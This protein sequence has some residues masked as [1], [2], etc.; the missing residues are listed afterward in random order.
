L[1]CAALRGIDYRSPVLGGPGVGEADVWFKAVAW[2]ENS[3]ELTDHVQLVALLLA[4]H[5]D[6]NAKDAFDRAPLIFAAIGGRVEIARMLIEAGADPRA[7]FRVVDRDCPGRTSTALHCAA[8]LGFLA[9]VD[10]LLEFG[11]DSLALS[12]GGVGDGLRPIGLAARS[13]WWE[14]VA[15]LRSAE[16]EA[17]RQTNCPTERPTDEERV[18][19]G[20]NGVVDAPVVAIGSRAAQTSPLTRLSQVRSWEVIAALVALLLLFV[21]LTFG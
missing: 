2:H 8:G 3:C 5:A 12:I 7:S 21:C 1:H 11:A 15:R 19:P 20:Q 17:L 9:M 16:K 13:G 10:V 4:A 14:I 18:N 6:P